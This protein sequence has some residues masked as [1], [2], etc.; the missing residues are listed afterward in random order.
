MDIQN[1]MSCKKGGFITIRHNDLCN[2]NEN[3][4]KEL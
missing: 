4:L 2:M 3:L 1:P